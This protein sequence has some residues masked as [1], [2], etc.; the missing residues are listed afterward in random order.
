MQKKT[1]APAGMAGMIGRR[2]FIGLAAA[3]I[4]V[5][6]TGATVSPAYAQAQA[7]AAQRIADHFASVK[8][9]MGE[10]VQFGPRGEQTAG[11]FYIERPGKLRFN[12]EQP[13]PMRVI[14][15]G[16]NVAIGNLKMKTWDVYPLSKTPLSLLLS[17]RIDLGHQMVRQVKEEQDLTTIVLGDKSIFGDQT[18]TLMFDPKTFEL[19]QWTVTDAQGKDTSVMIFNVQQG[20]NF[21]EKVFEVPYDDIRNRG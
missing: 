5:V 13:S 15:D 16:R 8:T 12:Y 21:D 11:K 6:A 7:S 20:V 9:M 2:G 19:R 17:D 4:A 10:F 3:G 14:S 18:I 1:F